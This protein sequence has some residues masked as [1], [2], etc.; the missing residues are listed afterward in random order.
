MDKIVNKLNS[1]D[2]RPLKGQ[3]SA[4][5]VNLLEKLKELKAPKD[6]YEFIKKYPVTS[7]FDKEVKFSG[8]ERSP[9][10]ESGKELLEV[11]FA[12]SDDPNNDLL[13]INEMYF[14]QLPP[15]ML[16]IGEIT[17]N[18]F[19][20]LSLS[21]ESY[22]KIYIWDR[23]SLTKDKSCHLVANSFLEFVISLKEDEE[24]NLQQ[25]PKLQSYSLADN[26]KSKAAEFLKKQKK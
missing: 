9:A 16:I 5:Y 17:G 21:P 7:I 25:K 12:I 2:I 22:G 15:K 4:T 19:L 13:L 3:Y 8:I 23:E 10:S 20:C 11:L 18:N 1:L 14:G 24:E 26:L 6:Y